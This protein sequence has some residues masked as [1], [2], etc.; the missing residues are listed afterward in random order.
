VSRL[1][2]VGVAAG[3]VVIAGGLVLGLVELGHAIRPED[4]ARPAP[5]RVV[6]ARHTAASKAPGPATL[7]LRLFN[8]TASAPP[9]VAAIRALA[10]PALAAA[11][12]RADATRPAG[13]KGSAPHVLV[14]QVGADSAEILA[15]D[16]ELTCAV[17]HG[18]VVALGAPK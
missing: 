7:C 18:R 11:L 15:P 1:G 13:F 14:T 3:V 6:P 5:I 17:S 16:F 8:A 9:N 4:V 10:A 12:L 2:R